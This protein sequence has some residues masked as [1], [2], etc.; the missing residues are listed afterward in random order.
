M[1]TTYRDDQ[2]YTENLKDNEDSWTVL[3]SFEVDVDIV[4][5]SGV[6]INDYIFQ[7][8]VPESTG[9]YIGSQQNAEC[10]YSSLPTLRVTALQSATDPFQLVR[11]K[12]G[13]GN[14]AITVESYRVS[15]TPVANSFGSWT[16]PKALRYENGQIPYRLC[17]TPKPAIPE[18]DYDK[19]FKL[20]ASEWNSAN[21]GITILRDSGTCTNDP[22]EKMVSASY[23]SGHPCGNYRALGCISPRRTFT[24]TSRHYLALK[25]HIRADPSSLGYKDWTSETREITVM[26][27]YLPGVVSHEFGHAAGLGHSASAGDLMYTDNEYIS[28]PSSVLYPISDDVNA[29]NALYR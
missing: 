6:A 26:H 8:R 28:S 24:S 3:T 10:D 29:M 19:A 23:I 20:G 16:L 7:I 17:N 15:R 13:D 25:M 18:L 27:P 14:S 21:A 4:G 1:E 12:R 22:N 5:P 9:V 2:P 11:C